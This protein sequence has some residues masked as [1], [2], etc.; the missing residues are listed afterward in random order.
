MQIFLERLRRL[1]TQWRSAPVEPTTVPAKRT[2]QPRAPKN[3]KTI[4]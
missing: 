3:A 1:M 4:S 2:R